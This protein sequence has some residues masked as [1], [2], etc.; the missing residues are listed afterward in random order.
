[1]NGGTVGRRIR[2]RDTQFDAIGTAMLERADTRE[3]DFQLPFGWIETLGLQR[4][5]QLR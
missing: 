5:M 3:P 1:M 2:E 4:L